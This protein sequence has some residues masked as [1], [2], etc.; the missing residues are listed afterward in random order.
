V[1]VLSFNPLSPEGFSG[2]RE[3]S[4]ALESFLREGAES[5]SARPGS[6]IAAI[7]G[8]WRLI[9]TFS[10]VQVAVF[11][12]A[13][14]ESAGEIAEL[15]LTQMNQA[16]SGKILKKKRPELADEVL[17][18][19]VAEQ[20]IKPV[21]GQGQAVS[22]WLSGPLKKRETHFKTLLRNLKSPGFSL[23]EPFSSHPHLSSSSDTPALMRIFIWDQSSLPVLIAARFLAETAVRALGARQS[24]NYDV[25]MFPEKTVL[26]MAATTPVRKMYQTY[27]EFQ[28]MYESLD[29]TRLKSAWDTFYRHYLAILASEERLLEK[30]V[31]V[32]ACRDHF[33][34]LTAE[35]VTA[36]FTAP[37]HERT[38]TAFPHPDM[39]SLLTDSESNPA[40]VVLRFPG[41]GERVDVGLCITW[42]PSYIAEIR[43]K[44]EKSGI[45]GQGSLLLQGSA[46]DSLYLQFDSPPEMLSQVL[47]EVRTMVL[48][49]A[50]SVA[51]IEQV[52]AGEGRQVQQPSFALGA[53]GSLHTFEL[54]GRL[55][56]IWPSGVGKPI[57][58][59]PVDL[60]LLGKVLEVP[61]LEQLGSSEKQVTFLR[62][63]WLTQTST[64]SGMVGIITRLTGKG[65]PPGHFRD[66]EKLLGITAAPAR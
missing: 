10:L 31:L 48:S 25:W 62:G 9:D 63:Q 36:E 18:H 20:R 41:A 21:F 49:T 29:L 3:L 11:L 47:S 56:D 42:E 59:I 52:L 64:S 6:A 4:E 23:V 24:W 16:F 44:L 17:R 43:E 35:P 7:G 45:S 2:H 12:P 66:I 13:A 5:D 40:Y 19:L 53:V 54:M 26:V 58:R 14:A 34:G 50:V 28:T 60:G 37:G 55:R 15:F 8:S 65:V 61:G 39:N 51:P 33:E 38:L 22:L 32:R 1:L 30:G 46:S 57:K 27:R